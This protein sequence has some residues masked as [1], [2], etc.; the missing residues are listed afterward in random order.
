MYG[1]VMQTAILPYGQPYFRELEDKKHEFGFIDFYCEFYVK[2]N[3]FPCMQ[4]KNNIMYAGLE[5]VYLK[6]SNGIT[7]LH[8]TTLDYEIFKAHYDIENDYGYGYVTF[9]A[10]DDMLRDVIQKNIDEKTY[11][12]N[13]EHY[14][15]YRRTKAKDNTNMLYGSFGLNPLSD[16]VKPFIN[17]SGIISMKHETELRDYRYIPI[18]SAITSRARAITIGAI[19]A[20]YDNWIYSDTDSM[21]LTKP[22]KGI[23]C[24]DTISGCWK[25]E[26]AEDNRTYRHGK[27]LRQKCYILADENYSPYHSVD[28]YGNVEYKIKCAGMP[29]KVKESVGWDNMQIGTT[30]H[31]LQHCLVKGGVCLVDMPYTLGNIK[32]GLNQ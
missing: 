22:A 26:G 5:N 6:E 10:R 19:D 2:K 23:K 12:S 30:F 20:N 16:V 8:M 28:K 29:D 15:P 32:R 24:D 31:K 25:C 14:D 4:I 21:Y 1:Y 27:F 11:W 13:R 3:K 17:D 9:Q 18:A 7:H